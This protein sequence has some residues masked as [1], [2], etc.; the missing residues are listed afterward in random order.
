M[1]NKNQPAFPV[2][3][4]QVGDDEYRASK[5]GDPKQFNRPMAGL[6]KREYFAGLAMQGMAANSHDAMFMM[7]AAQIATTSVQLADA[8][9]AELEK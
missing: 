9:I 7:K 6:S 3:M 8:L 5:P 1:E 4:Q 2:V